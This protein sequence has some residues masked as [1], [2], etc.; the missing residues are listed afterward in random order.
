M[1]AERSSRVGGRAWII[2][3]ALPLVLV[4]AIAATL[5]PVQVAL[6][7]APAVA[8]LAVGILLVAPEWGLILLL[9]S[10]YN[11]MVSFTRLNLER[12]SYVATFLLISVTAVVLVVRS[13]SLPL[14][15]VRPSS[16]LLSFFCAA[17]LASALYGFV[18]GNPA[19]YVV[20]D[21]LQVVELVPVYWLTVAILKRTGRTK[22]ILVATFLVFL[23]TVA[24]ELTLYS[25]SSMGHGPVLGPA[26]TLQVAA[27]ENERVLSGFSMAPTLFFPPLFAVALLGGASIT[28]KARILVGLGA[29]LAAL[30]IAVSFKRT[31][32]LSEAVAVVVVF[33][34][35]SRLTSFR[36]QMRYGAS[37]LAAGLLG[38]GLL[39]VVPV[40][41]Q[42]MLSLMVAR[43]E[44]TVTQILDGGNRGIE[45]RKL[46]YVVAAS[47]LRDAPLAGHGLGAQYVG[48]HRGRIEEKHF[49]HNTYIALV[50]RSGL[51]G[52]GLFVVALGTLLWR[53]LRRLRWVETPLD[54]AL[55]VGG[56]ATVVAVLV[57]G[58][59][60]GDLLTHPIAAYVG[61]L[62]GLCD[63]LV[64][65]GSGPVV[66]MPT[67]AEAVGRHQRAGTSI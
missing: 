24:W 55:L 35:M 39:S 22:R 23:V 12:W 6:L 32:W 28:P 41:K 59:T 37:L 19:S 20:S 1:K 64:V 34:L 44:Y 57:Q 66:P 51:L 67:M 5:A 2:A 4:A 63:H 42:S 25:L 65:Y 26:R 30:S 33:L 11:P 49:F 47:S 15:R 60:M 10:F 7:V 58:I 61:F 14:G 45:S 50:Y 29:V 13:R 8:A 52:L 9:I 54:Q 53:I 3:C 27:L 38:L 31:V 48:F 46:E 62:L 40:G 17:G 56:I 21:F 18:R 36:S 43:A 16:L